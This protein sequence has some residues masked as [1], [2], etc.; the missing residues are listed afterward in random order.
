MML[1]QCGDGFEPLFHCTTTM[2]G[3][4]RVSKQKQLHV[5]D[6]AARV[7]LDSMQACQGPCQEC[8]VN[9]NQKGQKSWKKRARS[10]LFLKY[11]CLSWDLER[12]LPA[13]VSKV[14]LATLINYHILIKG[15]KKKHQK[16]A[17]MWRYVL[18]SDEG[19]ALDTHLDLFFLPLG[20]NGLRER[21]ICLWAHNY[22]QFVVPRF[23]L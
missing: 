8:K 3:G 2:L 6:S 20:K 15:V 9:P 7:M 4:V 5:G 19:C 10:E 11:I 14:P 13:G 21:A 1:E 23:G 17:I 22:S 12:N 16:H 18:N